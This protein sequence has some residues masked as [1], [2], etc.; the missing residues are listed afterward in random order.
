[1]TTIELEDMGFAYDEDHVILRDVNLSLS[2]P[3]LYC[4][5]GPNGV[6]KS[7]LVKCLNKILQPTEGKVLI[8]GIDVK[9]M[10]YKDV[11]K[12]IGYV[13]TSSEDAFAM[14]VVEAIMIGRYNR[15]HW[16]SEASDLEV[17]YRAMKLLH[18][19]DLASRGFNE[20]SAGQ[21]QKVSIARG[22]VQETPVLILDEPTSNLDVNFQ[23]YVAEL[24]RAF[25][26]K[27]GI[28]VIMICHDLNIAAKYAHNIIM[29]ARPGVVYRTGPP[30]EVITKENIEFLYGIECDIIEVNGVPHVILGASRVEDDDWNGDVQLHEHSSIGKACRE[31]RYR[32]KNRI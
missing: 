30:A 25:S 26:E 3:G 4:I 9:E 29:M 11:S 21:H 6:G 12:E 23:V 7:T 31:F 22:L 32:I 8:N 10:S 19:R 15:K 1:M 24:L 17:V 13:P 5:I 16:G 20:L 28:T 27:Q 2:E 18:I 14:P